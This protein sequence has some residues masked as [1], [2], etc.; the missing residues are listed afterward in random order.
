MRLALLSLPLMLILLT[1]GCTSLGGFC[2]PGFTCDTLVEE[3]DDV[4][5]IE[6]LQA[7]P[8]NIPPEGTLKLVAIVSNVADVDA[9]IQEVPV[10]VHLYDHCSGM[11]TIQDVQ[12]GAEGTEVVAQGVEKNSAVQKTL[13]RGEKAQIE[14]TLKAGG[15][16][17]IPVESECTFKVRAAY[18]YATKSLTTLHFIDYQEMQRQISEGAY[19]Q[20]GS[21]ISTGHG[22]IKPYLRVEGTQ[23]IPVSAEGGGDTNQVNTVLS[24]QVVNKGSGFLSSWFGHDPDTEGNSIK[25]DL[26]SFQVSQDTQ[27]SGFKSFLN[28]DCRAKI[29]EK[30]L[31]LIDGESTKIM[32]PMEDMEIGKVPVEST[33]TIQVLLGETGADGDIT[34]GYWYEFRKQATVKVEPRF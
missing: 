34:Q 1:S 16:E 18:Q 33:R 19:K 22:P 26:V 30:G 12:G 24:L 7:L 5:V 23:P 11:F 25:K 4:I 8:D 17:S 10:F 14:W 2:I 29:P 27:G 31:K 13:L 32:C 21:Y 28:E 6:S 9:E 3:T 20:T 15:R